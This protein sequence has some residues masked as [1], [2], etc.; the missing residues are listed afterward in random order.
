MAL[1]G[2]TTYVYAYLAHTTAKEL[3][4]NAMPLVITLV[5]FFITL[6]LV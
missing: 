2:L 5:A 3:I 4:L 6:N 1:V